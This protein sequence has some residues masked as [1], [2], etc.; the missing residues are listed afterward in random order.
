M[1]STCRPH[2]NHLAEVRA[3]MSARHS[4]L[5]NYKIADT[6]ENTVHRR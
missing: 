6:R 4:E 5:G 2:V 1:T 3:P